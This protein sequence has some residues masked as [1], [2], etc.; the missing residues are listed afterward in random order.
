MIYIAVNPHIDL[1]ALGAFVTILMN[2]AHKRHVS[3]K[4]SDDYQIQYKHALEQIETKT[5]A[6]ELQMTNIQ[7]VALAQANAIKEVDNKVSAIQIN[8]GL[9]SS[10][11][12]RPN[13]ISRGEP[14]VFP[15][16]LKK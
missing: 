7:Q 14:P 1:T 5:Q 15:N 6:Y 9:T 16:Q 4:A 12:N 13:T 8:A 3:S 10:M 11:I 2:Y